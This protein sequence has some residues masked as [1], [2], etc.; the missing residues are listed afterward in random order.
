MP[1]SRRRVL[2]LPVLRRTDRQD[3]AIGQGDRNRRRLRHRTAGNRRCGRGA[4][5]GLWTGP[6][7]PHLLRHLGRAA[8]RSLQPYPALLRSPALSGKTPDWRAPHV[9]DL[10]IVA[11]LPGA[12]VFVSGP[13]QQPVSDAGNSCCENS[14]PGHVDKAHHQR[15]VLQRRHVGDVVG[16]VGGKAED[17]AQ[18]QCIGE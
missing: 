10:T 15:P 4:W 13:A 8:R 7:L 1:G 6:Q 11:A 12:A 18:H 2:C 17:G 3:R 14:S 5:F 9:P 16:A